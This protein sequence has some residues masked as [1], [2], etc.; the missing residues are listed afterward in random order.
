[1]RD[2]RDLRVPAR[3]IDGPS[4]SSKLSSAAEK[5]GTAGGR[6]RVGFLSQLRSSSM[7]GTAEL[8][9]SSF[10]PDCRAMSAT[11]RSVAAD[12]RYHAVGESRLVCV[13]ALRAALNCAFVAPDGN[14]AN[15]AVS[16]R[17]IS[18]PRAST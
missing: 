9:V 12:F 18:C 14:A 3:T 5:R 1:M 15:Y 4:S 17:A 10:N 2:A 11:L 16:A 8:L 6:G 7:G 13:D